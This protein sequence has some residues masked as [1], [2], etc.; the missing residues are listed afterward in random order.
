MWNRTAGWLLFAFLGCARRSTRS[1]A[2]RARFDD[3][4]SWLC[5]A[6]NTIRA[7]CRLF[8]HCG[9]AAAHT[10]P[11]VVSLRV[12]VH[13]AI[14]GRRFVLVL[15]LVDVDV[16]TSLLRRTTA[17]AT[18]ARYRLSPP[19]RRRRRRLRHRS[20]LF[21]PHRET[22]QIS[23]RISIPI[24]KSIHSILAPSLTLPPFARNVPVPSVTYR[25][26]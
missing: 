10:M 22:P 20:L 16:A 18:H 19:S 23:P 4:A 7:W 5:V 21:L 2:S 6:R 15:V 25:R 1:E 9:P 26:R 24:F 3:A 11:A 8:K 12:A 13:S 17:S 14:F